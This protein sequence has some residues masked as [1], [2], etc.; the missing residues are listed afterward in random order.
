M[1]TEDPL[2]DETAR[3]LAAAM[4]SLASALKKQNEETTYKECQ[5]FYNRLFGTG[6]K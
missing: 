4:L 3:W 6:T 5:S 1:K 2:T